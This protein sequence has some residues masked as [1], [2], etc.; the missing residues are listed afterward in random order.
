MLVRRPWR[1]RYTQCDT[2][3]RTYALLQYYYD[4]T[5]FNIKSITPI[6][7]N[8][9]RVEMTFKLPDLSVT[10]VSVALTKPNSCFQSDLSFKLPLIFPIQM[11]KIIKLWPNLTR[12][13]K[14]TTL[15]III[16]KHSY[17]TCLSNFSGPSLGTHNLASHVRFE[18]TS[19]SYINPFKLHI[20]AIISRLVYVLPS[21]LF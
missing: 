14:L 1:F 13:W 7:H 4:V 2:P 5:P 11:K 6:Q 12:W 15:Q 3:T 21:C 8:H 18:S 16:T 19:K 20:I 9:F 17:F 10:D